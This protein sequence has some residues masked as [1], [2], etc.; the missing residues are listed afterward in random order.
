MLFAWRLI[1]DEIILLRLAFIRNHLSFLFLWF[2]LKYLLKLMLKP[3]IA[4]TY[5]ISTVKGIVVNFYLRRYFF[6]FV[7][8][9]YSLMFRDDIVKNIINF[10]K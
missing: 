8:W 5:V 6:I 3:K 2:V 9:L 7:S 4:L 1:S 10:N